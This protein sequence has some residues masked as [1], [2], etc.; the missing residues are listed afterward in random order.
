MKP[1][2]LLVS[3]KKKPR[4]KLSQYDKSIESSKSNFKELVLSLKPSEFEDVE[5]ISIVDYNE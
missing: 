1:N 2:L 3:N 4:T 5:I